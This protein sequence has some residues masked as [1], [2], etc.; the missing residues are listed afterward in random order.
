MRWRVPVWHDIYDTAVA[1]AERPGDARQA[2]AGADTAVAWAEVIR[3]NEEEWETLDQETVL[4]EPTH[5][6]AVEE[7]ARTLRAAGV[8]NPGVV[9]WINSLGGR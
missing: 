4:K 9:E 7:L 3:R 8:R 2:L 5:A 6:Q 1:G